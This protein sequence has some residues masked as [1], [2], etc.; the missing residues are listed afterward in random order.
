MPDPNDQPAPQRKQA[1]IVFADLSGFTAM[2]EDLDPEQ[3]REIVNRY[4]ESLSAVVNRYQGTV[5]KYIGDCV[6]AVFGVPATRENDCERACCAAL[7]MQKAVRDLA[8]TFTGVTVRPPELH[9][10][11]NT[12]LVVAGGMGSTEH[13]PYTVMGDAV[14]L[15]SR[16]CHEAEN[17]QIALGES[18]W[19]M[20][21]H[22]FSGSGPEFRSIKGKSEKVPIYF[23]QSRSLKPYGKRQS[24]VPMV[25]RAVEMALAR[26]R[27]GHACAHHGSLLYITGDPGIGKSRLSSEMS[28]W[29][30][31]NG[32]RAVTASAQPLDTIQAYSVWRQLLE[33][34]GWA[35][36]A[37]NARHAAALRA[38]AGLASPDFELM[39]EANRFEAI[40]VARKDLLHSCNPNSRF[41]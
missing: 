11:V 34:L 21:R 17:G 24:Q 30:I 41:C 27:M 37:T 28:A 31:E 5:D 35:S 32:M 25:G 33:R 2:S 40:V 29:A 23:L 26:G 38:T 16:L 39:S 15:A 19:E 3:V 22:N 13:S 1:T 6:M 9:I 8:T 7:D 36:P 20:V 4:F 18:T 10:G 14:N 12:G